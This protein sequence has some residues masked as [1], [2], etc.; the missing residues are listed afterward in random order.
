[1]MISDISKKIARLHFTLILEPL[2][3]NA[4]ISD[5]LIGQTRGNRNRATP[6][7]AIPISH[8]YVYHQV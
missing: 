3:V 2:F 5:D 4:V 1:M 6:G 7:L 8:K